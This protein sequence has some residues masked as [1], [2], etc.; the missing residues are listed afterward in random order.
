MPPRRSQHQRQGS[1]EAGVGGARKAVKERQARIAQKLKDQAEEIERRR[2]WQAEAMSGVVMQRPGTTKFTEKE[3]TTEIE[4]R[5]QHLGKKQRADLVKRVFVGQ[6]VQKETFTIFR[7]SVPINSA[8]A[9]SVFGPQLRHSF[10]KSDV[11]IKTTKEDDG[12]ESKQ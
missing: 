8:Q 5:Y 6:A 11:E 12:T 7:A 9:L 2:R 4:R 1:Q 10:A 3:V